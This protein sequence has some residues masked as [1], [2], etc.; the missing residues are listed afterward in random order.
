MGARQ[1]FPVLVIAMAVSARAESLADV[2]ARMDKAALEFRSFSADVKRTEFTAV[3][4]ESETS[5]GSVRVRRAKGGVTGLMEF[6]E[7]DPRRIRF[8]G[9]TAQTYY[10]KA[11]RLEVI[12]IG[13]HG[14]AIEQFILLGFGTTAAE[15]RKSYD[16]KLGGAE[17]LN[18]IA[19]TRIELLPKEGEAKKLVTKIELWIPEGESSPIQEKVTEPSRNYHLFV[20]SNFKANPALPD[21]AFELNL[22]PNVKRIT[23]NK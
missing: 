6:G 4:S 8:D 21:S 5:S 16:M 15:M 2:L 12:D 1:L 23:P 14:G 17:Q 20:Y 11:N 3:L 18:G 13:K 22:P 19:T 9:R 7:P 10:P